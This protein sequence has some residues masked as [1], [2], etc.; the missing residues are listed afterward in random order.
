MLKNIR[1]RQ[2]TITLFAWITCLSIVMFSWLGIYY[3]SSSI[4]AERQAMERRTELRTVG[5]QLAASSDYLTEE[6]RQFAITLDRGHVNRYWEEVQRMETREQFTSRLQSLDIP[7]EERIL[8][9]EAR[10]NLTVLMA[11]EARSM[12][13]LLDVLRVP[14][15]DMP[16]VVAAFRLAD[17]DKNL[18][19]GQKMFKA[20]EILFDT[21]YMRIKN[22]VMG[23]TIV[24]F[25]RSVTQRTKA[26]L[27][28][29]QHATTQA[30]TL[31]FALS[32]GTLISLAATLRIIH[33]QTSR[34]IQEYTRALQDQAAAG[35]APYLEP[36]GTQE[37]RTFAEAFNQ[38]HRKLSVL[39]EVYRETAEN[40][41]TDQILDHALNII[42]DFLD[43]DGLAVHLLEDD[44]DSLR[45]RSPLG[46]AP[47]VLQ[48]MRVIK[49]A[50]LIGRAVED[51]RP[52]IICLDLLPA[53]MPEAPMY[54][55]GF[56]HL[57]IFPLITAQHVIG[58][59]SIAVKRPM[60]FT[61]QEEQLFTAIS[62]QLSAAVYNA[63]LFDS[64]GLEL[65]ERRRAQEA[66]RI[67]KE[68]AELATRVKSDFLAMMTHEIRTPISGIIG[69]SDILIK[70]ELS[71]RQRGYLE[72]ISVSAESLLNIINDILDVS[73]LEAGQTTIRPVEFNLLELTEE[74]ASLMYI[75]AK[76]RGVELAVRYNP[77]LP[78]LFLGDSVRI[79]QII[80]NLLGNA[81]KFTDRGH[82][83]LEVDG[84]VD[85]KGQ[86]NIRIAVEDTGIGI[87]AENLEK[88]FDRFSQV[89]NFSSRRFQG[90]GLGLTISRNLVELMNGRISVE[91]ELDKGSRFAFEIPLPVAETAGPEAEGCLFAPRKVLVAT[92]EVLTAG[93]LEEYLGF[94]GLQVVAVKSVRTA[95]RQ[96][97]NLSQTSS[98]IDLVLI[99]SDLPD[100]KALSFADGII[101]IYPAV[102]VMASF[103]QG[104]T[105]DIAQPELTLHKPISLTKLERL[106]QH[107][108][109]LQAGL[110]PD[111]P[112]PPRQV[113]DDGGRFEAKILIAE[114]HPIN[115]EVFAL[116]F[117]ELGCTVD[118]A[119]NGREAVDKF[120]SGAY[121][122]IFMDCQMPEMDGYSATKAIRR[123]EADAGG[124]I[125]IVAL[126]ASV[127]SSDCSQ[128]LD[129]GMDDYLL[130]P[131]K[132]ETLATVLGKY[133]SQTY[134]GGPGSSAPVPPEGD[135][136][137]PQMLREARWRYHDAH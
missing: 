57:A 95:L 123:I 37:L 88:I 103:Q 24:Q 101:P 35:N 119:Q 105:D 23:P 66:M 128:I 80:M 117:T 96:M 115:Q 77:R 46:F 116:L 9:V 67:A 106:L 31:L 121:D 3:V 58:A 50:G 131:V 39:Y 127:L 104:F 52:Q 16:P 84:A 102:A 48:N 47:E 26:E 71:P 11:V 118:V 93:I 41:D 100:I 90:T 13:L 78:R 33:T 43:I 36:I 133:C 1:F 72:T 49:R 109:H 82:I 132:K 74:A 85:A 86:A 97:E 21:E 53:G 64:L 22:S 55:A 38:S 137:K 54:V 114:D 14:E 27:E 134:R 98:P 111:A 87:A 70:T 99:D 136:P 6:A 10:D 130:K 94:C 29:A 76:M 30:I 12:R 32:L 83:F 15:S 19:E 92:K 75:Q 51:R 122:I 68:E 20:R 81:V 56:K 91:S 62:R 135:D 60:P 73:K 108:G 7:D 129:A 5:G 34:P 113:A 69:L 107:T 110:L 8:L 61:Q 125:P 17:E 65:A 63:Q 126:T 18:T 44:G 40:L 4:E 112:E 59:I 42:R 2:S 89:D 28:A 124:H 25:Q 45:L 120:Q 79:R